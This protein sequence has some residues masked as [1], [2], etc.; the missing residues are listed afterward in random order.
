MKY[1]CKFRGCERFFDCPVDHR[2]NV[3]QHS[4]PDDRT[5]ELLYFAICDEVDHTVTALT[6]QALIPD[7]PKQP[8]HPL[9]KKFGVYD[10]I[11]DFNDAARS[12]TMS[13]YQ[14]NGALASVTI[15]V[16]D[17][18]TVWKVIRQFALAKSSPITIKNPR[19]H[20]ALNLYGMFKRTKNIKDNR[21]TFYKF[22]RTVGKGC[23]AKY[24]LSQHLVR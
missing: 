13:V 2:L 9:Y 12:L 8:A 16:V 21:E 14:K 22:V 23:K 19:A 7:E 1:L 4:D 11:T 3:I 5:G 17:G 15:T 24:E 20:G 10:F 6:K 18:E